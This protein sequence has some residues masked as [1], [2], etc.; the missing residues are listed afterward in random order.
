MTRPLVFT[1]SVDISGPTPISPI[2]QDNEQATLTQKAYQRDAQSHYQNE[3]IQQTTQPS[4]HLIKICQLL[5][6]SP[7]TPWSAISPALWHRSG[8][9]ARKIALNGLNVS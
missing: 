7:S 3:P 8:Y 1:L 6:V 4:N 2:A 9:S 5:S